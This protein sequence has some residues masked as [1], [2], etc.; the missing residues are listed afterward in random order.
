MEVRVVSLLA[1]LQ[2]QTVEGLGNSGIQDC[3]LDALK[4]VCQHA[5]LVVLA[6]VEYV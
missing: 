1:M 6:E 4:A 3:R 2:R 5:D